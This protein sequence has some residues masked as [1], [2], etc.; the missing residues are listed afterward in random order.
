MKSFEMRCFVFQF[1]SFL[2]SSSQ[3]SDEKIKFLPQ[4]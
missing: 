4:E 3:E 2:A 1:S